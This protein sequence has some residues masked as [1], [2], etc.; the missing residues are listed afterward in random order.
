MLRGQDPVRVRAQWQAARRR[1]DGR[2]EASSMIEHTAGRSPPGRSSPPR[3]ARA[4]VWRSARRSATVASI[5]DARV[6]QVRTAPR[7]GA[8]PRRMGRTRDSAVCRHPGRGFQRWGSRFRPGGG[9]APGPAAASTG[10]RGCAPPNRS[11]RSVAVDHLPGEDRA[12]HGDLPPSAAPGT[13]RRSPETPGSR[14]SRPARRALALERTPG[15]SVVATEQRRA[16][17][18]HRY[19]RQRSGQRLYDAPVT[20]HRLGMPVSAICR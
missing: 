7:G 1:H 2:A 17:A 11:V 6:E 20:R 16:R 14:A 3:R 10:P 13:E 19:G 9:R 12:E 15:R 4:R 5:S 18:G 8:P